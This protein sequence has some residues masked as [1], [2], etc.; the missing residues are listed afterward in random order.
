MDVGKQ[1]ASGTRLGEIR[2]RSGLHRSIANLL[3]GK[4]GQEDGRDRV[5]RTDQP[6]FQLEPIHPGHTHVCDQTSAIAETIRSEEFWTRCERGDRVS[7]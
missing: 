6:L 1:I 5:A 4:R 3:V 7:E 2:Y